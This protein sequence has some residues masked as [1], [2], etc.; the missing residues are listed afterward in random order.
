M[1]HNNTRLPS[2][3]AW[4]WVHVSIHDV[5]CMAF[6]NYSWHLP[7]P[8]IAQARDAKRQL[9]DLIREGFVASSARP[10]SWITTNPSFGTRYLLPV[11][12]CIK[13]S[14]ALCANF[15]LIP[16]FPA[17][18][19][20]FALFVVSRTVSAQLMTPERAEQQ[21][22]TA[23]PADQ[24]PVCNLYI[25]TWQR[26]L[27]F[28]FWLKRPKPFNGAGHTDPVEWFASSVSL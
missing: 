16:C 13:L 3:W 5:C 23:L 28:A 22:S 7:V 9:K 20:S 2:T 18:L 25:F 14:P 21:F 8:E 4:S 10:L 12:K 6:A 26:I 19:G 11:K 15:L 1:S 24:S 27:K 17:C